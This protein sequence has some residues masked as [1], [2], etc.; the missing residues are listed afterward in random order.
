MFMNPLLQDISHRF[1]IPWSCQWQNK[2]TTFVVALHW[3][4]G[5]H[6]RIDEKVASVK[7]DLSTTIGGQ[8]MLVIRKFLRQAGNAT[9]AVSYVRRFFDIGDDE[10][11]ELVAGLARKRYIKK[12]ETLVGGSWWEVA[13]AGKRIAAAGG[14][15]RIRRAVADRMVSSLLQRVED[16][17][18][19]DYY[20]YRVSRI[21]GF[22]SYVEG[23]PTIDDIDVEITLEPKEADTEKHHHALE[24]RAAEERSK[25]RKFLTHAEALGW[26]ELEVLL[27]LKSRSRYLSLIHIPPEWRKSLPGKV[28]FDAEKK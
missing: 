7:A 14:T 10:A 6:I 16:V 23:E 5:Q 15:K 11:K 27:D 28:L 4:V 21:T 12:A 3:G 17:N 1:V 26:G 19:D 13:A 2:L 18:A 24:A 8:P 20:L 25:G 22:G 9:W